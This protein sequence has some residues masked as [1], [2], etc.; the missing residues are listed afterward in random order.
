[1]LQSDSSSDLTDCF[2]RILRINFACFVTCLSK[3]DI[4]TVSDAVLNMRIPGFEVRCIMMAMHRNTSME[5]YIECEG[6]YQTLLLRVLEDL[7]LYCISIYTF[8]MNPMTDGAPEALARIRYRVEKGG[9]WGFYRGFPEVAEA[10]D[11]DLYYN[12]KTWTRFSADQIKSLIRTEASKPG[13]MVE[14]CVV[15]CSG[16]I[17]TIPDLLNQAL[18]LRS[19]RSY[20]CIK[21]FLCSRASVSARIYLEVEPVVK[22]V[23]MRCLMERLQTVEE[24]LTFPK[25]HHAA[26]L[27][28]VSE[29]GGD[30][31]LG[32]CLTDV[33]VTFEATVY[34]RFTWHDFVIWECVIPEPP[35]A[36]W[37]ISKRDA[38]IDRLR[39]EM[40]GLREE[41]EF[42]KK[43]SAYFNE[44]HARLVVTLLQVTRDRDALRVSDGLVDW[45]DMERMR[46]QLEERDACIAQLQARLAT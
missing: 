31:V 12:M 39:V 24:I 8:G 5:I 23:L 14:W 10:L 44:Q 18:P 11:F 27:S 46:A 43:E 26:A 25:D 22:T 29:L 30:I 15:F 3:E 20:Y 34:T 35:V 37:V 21:G 13:E 7:K 38:V 9:F 17:S 19:R 2:P 41:E 42:R 32:G 40:L 36:H 4:K 45:S 16:D 6:L 33:P 28:L 1:M